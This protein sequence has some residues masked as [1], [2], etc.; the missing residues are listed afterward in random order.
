MLN[1]QVTYSTTLTFS[2]FFFAYV[3]KFF[4]IFSVLH[5]FLPIL[6]SFVEYKDENEEMCR[7]MGGNEGKNEGKV[8]IL[9]VLLVKQYI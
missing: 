3:H 2:P 8:G 6:E 9:F 7:D 5:E 1:N 4:Q